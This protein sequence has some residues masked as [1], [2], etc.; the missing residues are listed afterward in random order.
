M[1]GRSPVVN[2]TCCG[3]QLVHGGALA[4]RNSD[5]RF[6]YRGAFLRALD[7]WQFSQ[8]IKC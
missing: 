5:M 4:N 1:H 2:P 7:I 8:T 6:H 3:A